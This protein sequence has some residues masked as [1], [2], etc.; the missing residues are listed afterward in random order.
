MR[1]QPGRLTE[2]RFDL[3]I[4]GGGI[5]GI[6]QGQK[7]KRDVVVRVV[8]HRPIHKISPVQPFLG[9]GMKPDPDGG[10]AE[11]GKDTADS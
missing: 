9:M 3:L 8:E 1:R 7:L 5:N 10:S 11:K 4:I 2:E 6:D